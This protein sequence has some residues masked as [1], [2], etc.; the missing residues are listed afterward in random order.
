MTS[1]RWLLLLAVSVAAILFIGR[2]IAAIYGEWTWYG[3]MGALPVYR[4]RLWY[5][6]GQRA[7]AAAAAFAFALPNFYAVRR[8]IVSL[9][10]PRRIANLDFGE[11][12]PGRILTLTVFTLAAVVALALAVPID[13]WTVAAGARVGL[14]F[15]ELEPFRDRDVSF[16]VFQLPFERSLHEWAVLTVLLVGAMVVVLYAITPSLRWER[17]SFRVS[18]YVRR[19]LS[20]LS[21]CLLLLVAWSYRL[22]GLELLANGSG[23]DGAFLAFDHLIATPALTGLSLGALLA[24]FVV[25]W[26]GWHGYHRVLLV[27]LGAMIL[28]GPAERT[29]LP[30]LVAWRTSDAERAAADRPYLRTRAAF[31][32]RAFG[33]EQIAAAESLQAPEMSVDALPRRVG[34][35]DTPALERAADFTRRNVTAEGVDFDVTDGALTARVLERPDTDGSPWWMVTSV[36]TAAGERGHPPTPSSEPGPDASR[37]LADVRIWAGAPAYAVVSETAGRIA[38]PSFVG[39]AE[40]LGHAWHLRKPALAVSDG[41][42]PKAR[43]VYHRDLADRVSRIVPFFVTGASAQPVVQGDSLAWL[44]DLYTASADYPLAEPVPFDGAARRYVRH[45]ATAVVQAQTGRVT[46][47]G[48]AHPDAIART[49]I[50]QFP[51]LFHRAADFPPALAARRAPASDLLALQ[52][53]VLTRTGFAGDSLRPRALS[54]ADD[55]DADLADDVPPPFLSP[56]DDRTLARSLALVGSDDAV[57]GTL[58]AT[59]GAVPRTVWHRRAGAGQWTPLLSALQHAADS[60]GFARGVQS[61]RRGRVAVYPVPAG[62]AYVQSFYEWSAERPPRLTGVAVAVVPATRT[63]GTATP[64]LLVRTGRTLADAL[65]IA[66]PERAAGSAPWRARVAALYDAMDR[67]LKRGDWAAF[68]DAFTALGKLLRAAP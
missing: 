27:M 48:D 40:R 5:E 38:A 37:A 41:Y 33:I 7:A 68:G 66:E 8:S 23:T 45:V 17:G 10:L 19:H 50:A 62:L 15:G 36:A 39:W 64:P 20:V 22:D 57:W 4:M 42:P 35:W 12:V 49:W 26:S 9:V 1:R 18:T 55:A 13:D 53:S 11:A 30:A 51:E 52:G 31:T 63:D 56:G 54:F 16:Y 46:I 59:G 61:P 2:G 34:I 14:A 47:Y 32:R 6:W 25:G 29:V 65:G 21:A 60:A 28:A 58:V 44:V 43:I 67:A 24:S 3:A